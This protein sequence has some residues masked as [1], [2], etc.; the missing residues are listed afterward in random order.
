MLVR[1]RVETITHVVEL[2]NFAQECSS[3]HCVP[4]F[5]RV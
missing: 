5:L 2:L 1:Q 3:R 4:V